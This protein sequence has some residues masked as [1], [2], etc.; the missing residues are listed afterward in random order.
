MT[1]SVFMETLRRG[2]RGML[3]WGIGLGLYGFFITS[4]TQDAD[5]LKQYTE[6]AKS[7]PP[8]LLAIVGGNNLEAM[9]TPEGFLGLKFFSTSLL[10]TGIYAITCG[11]NV[12]ANEEDA[13]IMDMVL[14]LPVFRWRLMVEK[15]LAYTLMVVGVVV[16]MV[17][18]L[19]L[20]NETTPVR[21]DAAKLIQSSLNV[22]PG[23]LLILAFTTFVAV[24]FR[25]KST[26]I[27]A[28][29][30]FMLGSYFLN[31]LGEAASGTIVDQ[32]RGAS[33]FYYFDYTG[34]VMNGLNW[35]NIGLLLGV[36]A[37]LFGGS[38]YLFQRRDVGL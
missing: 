23:T 5:M 26:A 18:G 29:S 38:L 22:L 1:G 13:G 14:S 24:V 7:L 25:S 19:A 3:Y 35:G 11:L 34:V 36:A 6:L 16:L 21:V 15:F 37:L 17:I 28:V 20:G 8:A 31:T 30:I 2:W 32:L 27:G 33:F 4:F 10:V 12:T 9:A